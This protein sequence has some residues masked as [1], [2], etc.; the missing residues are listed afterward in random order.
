MADDENEWNPIGDCQNRMC[1]KII[2]LGQ[3]FDLAKKPNMFDMSQFTGGYQVV[4]LRDE[5]RKF[6]RFLGYRG[7]GTPHYEEYKSQGSPFLA[8][9]IVSIN[10]RGIN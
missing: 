1:N 7:D 4:S 9:S 8:K 5:D 2:G 10:C 3:G 6:Y